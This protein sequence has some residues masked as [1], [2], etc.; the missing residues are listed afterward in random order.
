M[1]L[2]ITIIIFCGIIGSISLYLTPSSHSKHSHPI[3]TKHLS[4]ILDPL[5]T[6][7]HNVTG[8]HIELYVNTTLANLTDCYFYFSEDRPWLINVEH[9]I[10]GTYNFTLYILNS[11]V[12]LKYIHQGYQFYYFYLNSLDLDTSLPSWVWKTDSSP[13][14]LFLHKYPYYVQMICPL[15]SMKSKPTIPFP[16]PPTHTLSSLEDD[17]LYPRRNHCYNAWFFT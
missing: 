12:T 17:K 9:N 6:L 3:P 7:S 2:E 1:K 13:C 8:P 10:T 4:P 16:H 14:V 5:L 15:I 11:N